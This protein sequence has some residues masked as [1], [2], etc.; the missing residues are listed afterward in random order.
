VVAEDFESALLD[1]EHAKE[2][3][4]LGL[5]IDEDTAVIG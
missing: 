1:G 2:P 4:R 5:G 3:A